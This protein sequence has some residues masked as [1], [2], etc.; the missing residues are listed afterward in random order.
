MLPCLLSKTRT[1]QYHSLQQQANPDN[2]ESTE[3]GCGFERGIFK[4]CRVGPS[5]STYCCAEVVW[6]VY[7]EER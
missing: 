6:G 5:G 2:E 1:S 3:S 7:N 4:W